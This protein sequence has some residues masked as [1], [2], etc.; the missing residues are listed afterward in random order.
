[1]V[2]TVSAYS[3][4][5][6]TMKFIS[7]AGP[8]DEGAGVVSR[9]GSDDSTGEHQMQACQSNNSLISRSEVCKVCEAPAARHYHYGAT[10]CFSCRAFFRRSVRVMQEKP[11]RCRKKGSCQ[12]ILNNFC[13]ESEVWCSGEHAGLRGLGFDSLRCHIFLCGDLWQAREMGF[14]CNPA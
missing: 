5:I 14:F 2:N 1:M 7:T 9:Q 8:N 11:Y 12:V 4:K 3:I 6:M 10:T 13:G